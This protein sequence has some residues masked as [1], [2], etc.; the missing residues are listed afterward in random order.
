MDGMP[1]M[2]QWYN[3]YLFRLQHLFIDHRVLN[4][5]LSLN[6]QGIRAFNFCTDNKTKRTTK[7]DCLCLLIQRIILI[8]F[9][10]Y[11][12]ARVAVS[13]SFYMNNFERRMR[14]VLLFLKIT[15]IR[16]YRRLYSVKQFKCF[17]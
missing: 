3:N 4:Y 15:F 5:I 9:I 6:N 2:W 14:Y 8:Y 7:L 13:F 11:I 10:K 16:K 17:Q 12:T 1:Y